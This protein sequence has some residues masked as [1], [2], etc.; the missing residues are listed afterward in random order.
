MAAATLARTVLLEARRGALPW[1]ALGALATA[2]A[3]A[4]FLSQLALTETRALQA[5]VFAAL[6]RAC[7]VFTLA[8]HVATSTLREVQDKGLELMLALPV[9]RSVH[10]LGRLAGFAACG[11]VLA[12]AFSAP[13]LAWAPPGAV[14][15]WGVSLAFE[16]AL[17]AAAALFFA[18]SLSSGVAALSAV[19]GLYLLG[20]SMGAI[21]AMAASPLAEP[22][23]GA[24]AARLLV[25][26]VAL[27][28]PRLEDATR[29]EWLLYGAPASGPYAG[30]LG[31]LLV[32]TALLVAAGLFD[33]QRKSV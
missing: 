26:A 16:C 10:Y 25:D 9:S 4:A 13:L 3:L 6:L 19:A 29:T 18:M 14:A 22:G 24:Q 11:V 8:A 1:V 32:Y 12:A 20:R 31:A 27:V 30:V 17:V 21:Q 23:F 15:A 33:F 7:A 2:L 28:L 5:S